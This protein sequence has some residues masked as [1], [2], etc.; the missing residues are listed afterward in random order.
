MSLASRTFL[1]LRGISVPSQFVGV[2][3]AADAAWQ[4]ILDA[5]SRW[6]MQPAEEV[7]ADLA[8]LDADLLEEWKA[9]RLRLGNL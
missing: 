5:G 1:K 7:E 4:S 6:S 9:L 2:I 3:E 8:R